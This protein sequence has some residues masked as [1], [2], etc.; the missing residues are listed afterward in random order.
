VIPAFPRASLFQLQNGFNGD[1]TPACS[2]A[3][4]GVETPSIDGAGLNFEIEGRFRD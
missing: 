4:I 1:R 2:G 3:E